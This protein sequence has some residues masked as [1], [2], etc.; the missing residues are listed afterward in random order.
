MNLPYY[1]NVNY[2]ICLY[3]IFLVYLFISF[4]FFSFY[5]FHMRLGQTNRATEHDDHVGVKRLERVSSFEVKGGKKVLQLIFKCKSCFSIPK[6]NMFESTFLIKA[7]YRH[8]TRLNAR[9][10]MVRYH[11]THI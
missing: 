3:S 6:I 8:Q 11:W 9:L 4:F 1:H 5:N 7:A 10:Q 2:T